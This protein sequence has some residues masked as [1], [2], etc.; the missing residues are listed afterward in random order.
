MVL[1]GGITHDLTAPSKILTAPT[2]FEAPQNNRIMFFFWANYPLLLYLVNHYFLAAQGK[3]LSAP[4]K[5]RNRWAVKKNSRAARA[6]KLPPQVKKILC[7]PLF[8]SSKILCASFLRFAVMYL[9]FGANKVYRCK[10]SHLR[11]LPFVKKITVNFGGVTDE[12]VLG[13]KGSGLFKRISRI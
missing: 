8:M 4:G 1:G 10:R 13:N 12:C 7:T 5:M 3:F 2:N 9:Y 6:K 11:R